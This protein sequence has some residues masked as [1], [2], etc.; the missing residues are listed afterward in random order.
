MVRRIPLSLALCLL[1]LTGTVS[2]Q[3]KQDKPASNS[4]K[5]SDGVKI[6]YL[7]PGKQG[8]AAVAVDSACRGRVPG[9]IE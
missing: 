8:L 5:T 1:T 3:D 2:A 6:H 7:K 9:A 4:F